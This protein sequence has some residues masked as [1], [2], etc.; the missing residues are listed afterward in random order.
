MVPISLSYPPPLSVAL[1]L[2]RA[3]DTP[4]SAESPVA[5]PA[6]LRGIRRWK[7]CEIVTPRLGTARQTMVLE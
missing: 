6:V 2:S 4:A 5:D 7:S 1:S 3:T